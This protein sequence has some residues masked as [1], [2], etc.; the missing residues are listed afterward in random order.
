MLSRDILED[1][2]LEVEY[3][4]QEKISTPKGS[5]IVVD[6]IGVH[7]DPH[8]FPDPESFKPSRWSGV[9]EQNLTMFGIGPRSCIGRKFTQVEALTFLAPFLRD[10]R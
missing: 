3:P 9:S 1:I 7:H 4:C 8:V 6:M 10:C 5:Q 2:S